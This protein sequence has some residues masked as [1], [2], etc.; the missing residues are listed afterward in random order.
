KNPNT[1]VKIEVEPPEDPDS[2]ERKFKRINPVN[3]P[4]GWKKSDVP[5]TII[6]PKPH[7]QLVT[8]QEATRV[9]KGVVHNKLVLLVDGDA[10]HGSQQA[11]VHGS[12][13]TQS[14]PQ[15]RGEHR[16][17]TDPSRPDPDSSRNRHCGKPKPNPD[18]I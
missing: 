5:T 13:T 3:G 1:T 4:Q 2:E 6:P 8:I 17:E 14:T 11:G 16:D 9:K 15:A 10:A 12:Q 18:P 7:P